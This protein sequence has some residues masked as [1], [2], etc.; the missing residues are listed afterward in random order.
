MYR[1]IQKVSLGK[2]S[3]WNIC[4]A[5]ILLITHF[6]KSVIVINHL[7]LF[8]Q[9]VIVILLKMPFFCRYSED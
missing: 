1:I 4:G 6:I 8:V 9:L 5:A 2:F 3:N 7:S